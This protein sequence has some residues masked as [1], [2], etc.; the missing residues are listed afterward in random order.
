MEVPFGSILGVISGP[1]RRPFRGHL[2]LRS[3]PHF[4]IHLG[5]LLQQNTSKNKAFRVFWVVLKGDD[6]GSPFDPIPVYIFG[7]NFDAFLEPFLDTT[8][9]AW[10]S[11][12]HP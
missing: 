10:P 5:H 3:G 9:G 4:G 6:L 1:F 8:F 12:A 7:D 2:W 11:P